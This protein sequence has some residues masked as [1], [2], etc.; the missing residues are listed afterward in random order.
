MSY[1]LLDPVFLLFLIL[2]VYVIVYRK[3][4]S[5]LILSKS[6]ASI[7]ILFFILSTPIVSNS[8]VKWLELERDN[9]FIE[10]SLKTFDS[11]NIIVLG[12]GIDHVD[13]D[14]LSPESALQIKSLK[15]TLAAF[16]LYIQYSSIVRNIIISGGAGHDY[17]EAD[18][19][20][21]L[22]MHLGV[23][24]SLITIDNQS[25]NTYENVKN[26]LNIRP[27]L[28]NKNNILITSALHMKRAAFVFESFDTP[29]LEYP[30]DS[31]Y[32]DSNVLLPRLSSLQKTS[33][34]I[35]EALAYYIYKIRY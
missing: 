19:M 21:D 9:H 22:L 17:R 20:S 16:N 24:R 7:I 33:L 28:I 10:E 15:R 26:I 1:I 12:G 6:F 18:A 34:V 5:D 27:E 11:I 31:I 23:E 30:V 14:D 8:L 3:H 25:L 2:I 32:L 29:I 35:R 4:R 13:A